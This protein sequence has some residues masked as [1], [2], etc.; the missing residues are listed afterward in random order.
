VSSTESA[1]ESDSD[2]GVP[3]STA[4]DTRTEAIESAWK[5]LRHPLFRAIWLASVASQIGTWIH[6]VGAAWLMTSLSPS[7]FMV[8][9]VQ[10]A[11]A[12]PLFLLAVPAGALADI[13]DRRRMLIGTQLWMGA[14]ALG[15]A[16]STALGLTGPVVLLLFTIALSVGAAL[17]AP[18]WQATTPEL[19][20]PDELPLAVSLNGMA[21]NLSR[22]IGP[23][24]GGLLVGFSGPE[25]AF[26]LNAV[27][28]VA[29]L[30]V[31]VRWRRAPSPTTLPAERFTN[32]VRAGLRYA[33]YAPG[34]RSVLARAVLFLA[35]ASA[36][37]AL[38]PHLAKRELGLSAVG[39]GVLMAAVGIGAL[40]AANVLPRLRAKLAPRT[41][42]L[43]ATL[44][45]AATIAGLSQ[46]PDVRVAWPT[47][48]LLG[49]GWL[50]MLSSLHLGAQSTAAGW[51]RARAL[52]VFLFFFFGSM[53]LGSLGWGA[54]A[55]WLGVRSTLLVAGG[56][57]A[58]AAGPALFFPLATGSGPSLAP[59]LH[60][61][62][63][64]VPIPCDTEAG[65]VM[66]TIEYRV[67]PLDRAELFALLKRLRPSRLRDGGFGWNV[68][69]DPNVPGRI[70]E[71]FYV[72]SWL[73]H[74][75]QHERVTLADRE[76]QDR[77]AALQS[78]PGHPKVDHWLTAGNAS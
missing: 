30:V 35:P 70:T 59:S 46:A 33:R 14:T 67:A 65:P 73:E 61:P 36:L 64:D 31:L 58:L 16:V 49:T 27:S 8:S 18:A 75:R 40:L 78:E 5:P 76:I 41:L 7:P 10:A 55:E 51:V 60:W 6:D 44:V 34:F 1:V 43:V 77:I 68:F 23:A 12:L 56:V 47:L 50:V 62:A 29:G 20:P 74:L 2:A 54:L 38:L 25:S 39:Y 21:I 19:V 72:E 37:W 57:T 15:L 26:A 13:V 28:F 48:L 53:A 52:A 69:E 45:V 17:A 63:P 4:D 71:I 9:L 32:A 24:I 66:V 3:A 22:S 11:T 42:T